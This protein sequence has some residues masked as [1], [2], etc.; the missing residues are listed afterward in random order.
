LRFRLLTQRFYL[1]YL[2]IDAPSEIYALDALDAI[3]AAEPLR[4]FIT[5]L[6]N[7]VVSPHCAMNDQF[8]A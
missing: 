8:S 7:I 6:C 5:E 3:R 2:G 4:T 1:T